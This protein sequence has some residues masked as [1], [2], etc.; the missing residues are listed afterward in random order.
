MDID[1]IFKLLEAAYCHRR[2]TNRP[3]VTLTW[4][5]S[6]DGK[7]ST[8]STAQ[9]IISGSQSMEV[10]HGLRA[11]HH[12]ILVGSNTVLVDNPHLTTRLSPL[13]RAKLRLAPS[14]FRDSN[15][16]SVVQHNESTILHP[17]PVILDS[18]QRVE[19]GGAR[20]FQTPK[21]APGK[22][23]IFCSETQEPLRRMSAN[24]VS[25]ASKSKCQQKKEDTEKPNFLSL[26]AVVDHLSTERIKSVM[27]EGG[28]T[29]L[30][31]FFADELWD[32]AIVTI[33][34]TVFGGGPSLQPTP[35]SPNCFANLRF[36]K[37][38]WFRVGD[39]VVLV[40][41]PNRVT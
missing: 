4:A 12:T 15:S 7:L 11:L 38:H 9:T 2:L 28:A 23:F 39:D 22:P 14:L 1:S 34:P 20:F 29:V 27:V 5:Q 19:P 18:R 32:I 25:V 24:V 17:I 6:L 10:T 35:E 33:A 16:C 37:S 40:G 41:F 21:K 36:S 8:T 13:I 26:L 3:W 31:S 30:S